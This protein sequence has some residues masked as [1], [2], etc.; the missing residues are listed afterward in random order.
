MPIETVDLTTDGGSAFL[1]K[2]GN[3]LLLLLQSLSSQNEAF[4]L[5]QDLTRQT[6]RGVV[7]CKFWLTGNSTY[8][9]DRQRSEIQEYQSLFLP[10]A[11]PKLSMQGRN[12]SILTPSV[13]LA[14]LR[15]QQVI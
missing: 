4:I 13:R 6:D 8:V 11:S 10:T 2:F 1:G 3:L 14:R 5:S 7:G 15:L 9:T 12:T